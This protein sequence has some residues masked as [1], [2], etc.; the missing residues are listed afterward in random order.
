VSAANDPSTPAPASGLGS[1]IP[2]ERIDHAIELWATGRS[3]IWC[4]AQLRAKWNVSTRAARRYLEIAR[5]RLR[6]QAPTQDP[7]EAR[8]EVLR[9][10]EAAFEIAAEKRDAKNMI[11][12]TA[13][14]AEVQG[15]I[16][17]RKVEL[18]GGLN[19]NVDTAS[20][21]QRIAALSAAGVEAALSDAAPAGAQ[22]ALA[23]GAAGDR[24]GDG[25]SGASA[26]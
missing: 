7:A 20:L 24:S 16:G 1:K 9:K 6:E 8:D 11:A 4:Q 3:G 14:I 21:A 23:S 10:L 19:L 17:T 13:R 25:T 26:A 18:S 5:K 15:L 12:A 2:R 22:T